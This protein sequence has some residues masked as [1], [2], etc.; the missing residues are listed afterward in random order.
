MIIFEPIPRRV[1]N[2]FICCG[3]VFCASS[4]M[5]TASLSVRPRMK[6][7]GAIWMT[8]VSIRSLRLGGGDEFAE[9]IVERLE[10]GVELV[11]HL[12][13]EE[14]ELLACFDGRAGE[15]DTAHLLCLEGFDRKTDGDEVFPEPAAP[16][17][18]H[19][20]RSANSRAM[21]R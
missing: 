9:S 19:R 10:V 1:R 12:A 3:V 15:D 11:L 17:A 16:V 13:R 20:S 2:I 7:S 14:A 5:T 8:P 6:A 18:K 4:R 21:R